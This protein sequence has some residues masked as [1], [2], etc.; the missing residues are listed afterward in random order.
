MSRSRKASGHLDS[1]RKQHVRPVR[2][3]DPMV[4]AAVAVT[5]IAAVFAFGFLLPR[6]LT[7]PAPPASAPVSGA[8][9][10]DTSAANAVSAPAARAG[11]VPGVVLVDDLS[12]VPPGAVEPLE[13]AY[14]HRTNRC[15]SCLKAEELTRKALDA[16]YA[17]RLQRGD[18]VMLV[19]DVQQPADPELVRRYEAYGSS[20]YL[21]VVKGGVTYVYPVN[22]IW[23]VL[24]DEAKF[25]DVVRAKIDSVYGGDVSPR[26]DVADLST[27]R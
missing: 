11:A 8:M 19:E 1:R 5:A 26:T 18:M 9:S 25:T 17:D 15:K 22:D 20:L 13:V 16:L 6:V 23:L 4:F 3:R 27:D 12:Q 2:H 7:S 14:F 24:C 10:P 21:G